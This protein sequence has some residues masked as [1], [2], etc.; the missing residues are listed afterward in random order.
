MMTRQL[1]TR[2][3][4]SQVIGSSADDHRSSSH[5]LGIKQLF[6]GSCSIFFGGKSNTIFHT[7][8]AFLFTFT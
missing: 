2:Q 5:F 3:L 6:F 1:T 7:K 4:T 8:G